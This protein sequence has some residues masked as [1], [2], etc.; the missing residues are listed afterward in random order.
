MEQLIDLGLTMESG[1]PPHFIW[2]KEG[3]R[4][5]RL[6]DGER[7]ELWQR[8]NS[9]RFTPGFDWAIR[10][11][12]RLEDDLPKLYARFIT[13]EH[14]AEAIRRYPG[15][16]LTRNEPWESLV[17]YICSINRAIPQIRRDVQKLLDES[18]WMKEPEEIVRMRLPSSLG[19]R[20]KY[21][22][23]AAWMVEESEVSLGALHRMDYLKARE[24][25]MRLPGVGP[26]V[27]DCVLLFG[28]GKLE[29]FPADV[30]V[31]RAMSRLYGLNG[32]K[33]IEE[34]AREKWGLD[35]GYAQQYLY[36]Y[37][38]EALKSRVAKKKS[39]PKSAVGF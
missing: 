34:Y 29:A 15:L 19:F 24:E 36:V 23:D 10:K 33:R 9:M 11:L 18:G 16:R 17:C 37:A 7:C 4:Y 2:N 38:R 20:A 5:W 25:L 26:K 30:W 8:G 32:V 35:A 3:N 14:L 27:A 22:R 31:R 6:I 28:Y 1:Q 39:A 21:L 13:D 12:L